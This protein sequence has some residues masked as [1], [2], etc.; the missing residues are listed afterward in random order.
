MLYCFESYTLQWFRVYKITVLKSLYRDW[1]EKRLPSYTSIRKF[2]GDFGK[3]YDYIK[4]KFSDF[5]NKRSKILVL[6]L[7]A[8]FLKFSL[9]FKKENICGI[10]RLPRGSYARLNHVNFN[11]NKHHLC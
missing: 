7:D 4:L 2:V 5:P 3:N 6:T 9:E 1:I 10:L 11:A 8:V